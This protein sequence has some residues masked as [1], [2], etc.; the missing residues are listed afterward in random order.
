MN[1]SP[2]KTN[3]A[4]LGRLVDWG[5][6]EAWE[7]FVA[8]YTPLVEACCRQAGLGEEAAQELSQQIWIEL[9]DRLRT[10][11]YD[12]SG[13]FRAWLRLLCRSRI[14][15]RLRELKLASDVSLDDFPGLAGNVLASDEPVTTEQED[16]SSGED[17][18]RTRLLT[19]AAA[20]QA[21]VKARVGPETWQAFWMVAV[22]DRSV[23]EAAETL[24]KSY[25]ATFVAQ[26]RVKERLRVEARRLMDV[27]RI[28]AEQMRSDGSRN[29]TIST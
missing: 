7:A 3:P 11:R 5:D 14:V 2:G 8:C 16:E 26:K 19:V 10:F 24:G 20:A 9:A 21:A 22:E 15:D 1:P 6:S 25:A 29:V 13:S 12:P 27:L 18:D 17:E 23:K 4:L 28:D